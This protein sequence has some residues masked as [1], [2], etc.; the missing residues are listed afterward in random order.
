MFLDHLV[1]SLEERTDDP[2]TIPWPSQGNP[3]GFLSFSTVN[4]WHVFVLRLSLRRGVPEIVT[5][6]FERAQ[7]LL[8]L[9]WIDADLIKAGEL[10]GFTALELALKGRYGNKHLAAL[11]KHL[12]E[13]DG[14]TDD[15]VPMVRR[16]G[17][18][19]VTRL[20]GDVK[21]SLSEIRN[22]LAHGY[23]FDALPW[24]GLL[25]LIRDLIEYVYRD[26]VHA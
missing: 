13:K 4:E 6:K 25:E 24:S 1:R 23:P 18:T 14:L 16:Y 2:L 20:T 10:V 11:L 17:G 22:S 19:V 12:V 9:G 21:P 7:K 15:R 8:F 26:F 3:V 5:R